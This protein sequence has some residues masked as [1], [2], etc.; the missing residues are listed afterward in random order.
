MLGGL[1]QAPVLG[2]KVNVSRQNQILPSS[3]YFS[4]VS[5]DKISHGTSKLIGNV[6]T[7]SCSAV[8]P[9]TPW[10]ASREQS[11]RLGSNVKA[12]ASST[13]IIDCEM[14]YDGGKVTKVGESTLCDSCGFC[15][16]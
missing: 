6:R 7:V 16:W 12:M 2:S 9:A 5:S 8:R 10:T 14:T 1:H 4:N 15:M 13:S 11:I 3:I